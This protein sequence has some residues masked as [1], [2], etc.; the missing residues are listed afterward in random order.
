MIL[1][2][3]EYSL[4]P[5]PSLLKQLR[6]FFK[7]LEMEKPHL[8]WEEITKLLH[9]SKN[10]GNKIIDAFHNILG[11]NKK[12][13]KEHIFLISLLTTRYI[14]TYMYIYTYIYV[15]ICVYTI[16]ILDIYYIYIYIYIYSKR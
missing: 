4:L 2:L 8:F 12:I 3:S 16:Y 5:L 15:Y 14:N 7:K 11:K 13:N 6:Y 1:S 9:S 10:A